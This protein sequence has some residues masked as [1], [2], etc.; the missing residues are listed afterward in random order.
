MTVSLLLLSFLLQ[1]LITSQEKRQIKSSYLTTSSVECSYSK[2]IVIIIFASIISFSSAFVP[3]SFK[4]FKLEI[5][6]LFP[7][8]YD[9]KLLAFE[10]RRNPV[11]T[12]SFTRIKVKYLFLVMT[13][14][15][16]WNSERKF[17]ELL[18]GSRFDLSEVSSNGS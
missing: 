10:I 13:A 11:R 17:K 15:T 5:S 8:V 7:G 4:D 14:E 9:T 2:Y 16:L 1:L 12:F 6:K 18:Y 3:E